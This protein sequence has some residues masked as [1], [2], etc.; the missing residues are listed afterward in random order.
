M[1]HILPPSPGRQGERSR[2]PSYDEELQLAL[3]LSE[4]LA[5]S[6]AEQLAAV[7]ICDSLGGG[8]VE[9]AAL[10]DPIRTKLNMSA[11]KR[12]VAQP[13]SSGTGRPPSLSFVALSSEPSGRALPRSASRPPC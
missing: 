10:H 1:P 11:A 3:T 6:K 5:T 2:A 12:Q 8:N 4:S 7:A 9:P 13:Y